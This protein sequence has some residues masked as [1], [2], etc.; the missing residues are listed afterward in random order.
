[1]EKLFYQ[2]PTRRHITKGEDCS[3]PSKTVPDQTMSIREIVARFVRGMPIS[4]GMREPLYSDQEIDL[5]NPPPDI[6]NMDFAEREQFVREAK[7]E[8]EELE[9]K[10]AT[11]KKDEAAKRQKKALDKYVEKKLSEKPAE[12]KTEQNT[13]MP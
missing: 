6:M 2:T 11:R 4:A 5:D 1:M 8:L 3:A 9:A 10:E 12:V 13:N 7:A